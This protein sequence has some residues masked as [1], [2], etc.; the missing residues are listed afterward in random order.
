MQFIDNAV[1]V[2]T[3][4]Q[5]CC[6]CCCQQYYYYISSGIHLDML[7]PMPVDQMQH[8]RKM[9][10]RDLVTDTKFV[11]NVRQIDDEIEADYY[12]SLR[13]GIGNL[14]TLVSSSS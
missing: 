11:P 7:A 5:K 9:V 3:Q 1:L 6:C 2:E 13:K 12:F 4:L 14:P 10:P 8:V